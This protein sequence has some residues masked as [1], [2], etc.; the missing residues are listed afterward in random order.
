[1]QFP[2]ECIVS[3]TEYHVFYF[4]FLFQK[5]K[6]YICK[7]YDFAVKSYINN[8]LLSIVLFNDTDGKLFI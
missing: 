1:M 7:S 6:Q 3:N 4:P 8:V 2:G 5:L